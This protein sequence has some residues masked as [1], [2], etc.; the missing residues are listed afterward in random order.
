MKKESIKKCI[1]IL[2]GL[3]CLALVYVLFLNNLHRTGLNT[4]GIISVFS[5]EHIEMCNIVPFKTIFEYF[6]RLAEHTINTNTVVMNLLV[7]LILFLPM[8]MAIPVLFEKKINKFW[9]FLLFII[10]I[11]FLVEIIQFITLS[12]STDIDDIILNTIS[13]CIGYGIV[14][15]KFVRKLLK[16]DKQ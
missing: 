6:Q 3:Y 11:T 15:L 9:K 7:N 12:G 1:M 5:K 8:G 13:G 10:F 4:F 14:Q 16:L 2:F